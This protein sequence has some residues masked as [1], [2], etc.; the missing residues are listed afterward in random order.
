[1]AR[2]P[3][4]KTYKL[5]IGGEFPRSES[6]RTYEAQSANVARASRKDVDASAPHGALSPGGPR[7]PPTTVVRCC[8]AWRRMEAVATILGSAPVAGGR[9]PVAGRWHGTMTASPSSALPTGGGAVLQLQYHPR[10][11]GVVALAVPDEPR[12]LPCSASRAGVTGGNARPSPE[13]LHAA[14]ELPS[15]A[16][17]TPAG[18]STS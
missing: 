12:W 10:P 11:I 15:D 8:T 18:V 4:K 3:V 1:M 2:L 13:S 6:G 14:V 16:T 9:R 7:R 17:R 5:Y